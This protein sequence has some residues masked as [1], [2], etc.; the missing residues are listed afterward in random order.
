MEEEASPVY[1][2]DT[3]A[4]DI[5]GGTDNPY[6]AGDGQAAETTTE[7]TTGDTSDTTEDTTSDT[8]TEA[9]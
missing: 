4:D 1:V 8:T 6:V 7:Q 3:P 2:G 5:A 9:Q